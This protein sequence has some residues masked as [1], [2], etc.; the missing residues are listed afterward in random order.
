MKTEK[1]K[2]LVQD[3]CI[4]CEIIDLLT[5]CQ[6]FWGCNLLVRDQDVHYIGQEEKVTPFSLRKIAGGVKKKGQI[7]MCTRNNI[8]WDE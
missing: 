5:R 7:Q 8:I 3:D 4:I 6:E 2:R 1:M